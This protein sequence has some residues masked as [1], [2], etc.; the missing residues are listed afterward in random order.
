MLLKR[1]HFKSSKNECTC[2]FTGHRPQNLP[3]RFY[4]SDERCVALKSKLRE[5]IIK[6][7]EQENVR[8]FITG[9]A[10][11]V[12]MYAAEIVLQ[13]KEIYP[14]ITLEAAIPC[15]TQASRWSEPLRDRYYR[16]AELC[17]KET[18]L[19]TRYTP[20]CMQKRNRYMVDHAD[21]VLA[22]WDGSPSGTGMTTT[23]A[24]SSGKT[25]W[26]IDPSTAGGARSGLS[27]PAQ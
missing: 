9:M 27:C 5:C 4:E 24:R 23:Y 15:E 8:H 20:D 7:I 17:D 21:F 25:V 19:Q 6:L 11:G 10:I 16:I 13:L 26:T 14:Y 1:F 22:V 18:M 12:D 2:A 3:F